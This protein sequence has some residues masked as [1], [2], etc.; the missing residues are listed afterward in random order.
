M[1]RWCEATRP[2]QEVLCSR[3]SVSKTGKIQSNP[4]AGFVPRSDW[5][6]IPTFTSHV[7]TWAWD[8]RVLTFLKWNAWLVP[9]LGFMSQV[10]QQLVRELR[11]AHIS[12]FYMRA[13]GI[14]L[15]MEGG[16][17]FSP[18]GGMFYMQTNICVWVWTESEL[19]SSDPQLQQQWLMKFT[20]TINS[21]L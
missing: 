4:I 5:Q 1:R 17:F 9:R 3:G 20:E 13:N 10:F 14:R 6:D 8:P 15:H 2:S 7:L 18:L 16:F 11:F 12:S 21:I 19:L